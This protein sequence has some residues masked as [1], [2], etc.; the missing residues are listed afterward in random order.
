MIKLG[1]IEPDFDDIDDN[2]AGPKK[3]LTFKYSA[4]NPTVETGINH[5]N[6]PHTMSL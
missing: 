1:F 6:S 3:K 2:K 4:I 5:F